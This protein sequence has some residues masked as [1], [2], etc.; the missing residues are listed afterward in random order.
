[1]IKKQLFQLLDVKSE[2]YPGPMPKG[3]MLAHLPQIKAGNYWVTPKIDGVRAILLVAADC[4]IMTRDMA[5]RKVDNSPK[6]LLGSIDAVT[7]LDGELVEGRVFVPCDACWVGGEKLIDKPFSVRLAHLARVAEAVINAPPKGLQIAFKP[8]VPVARIQ[9]LKDHPRCDGLILVDG[10]SAYVNDS[11]FK[12]K[13]QHTIDFLARS[14]ADKINLIMPAEDGSE[15]VVATVSTSMPIISGC[16][17]ECAIVGSG[18]SILKS[19][20]DKTRANA[21][22]VVAETI[23]IIKENLDFDTLVKTFS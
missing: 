9:E 7:V 22:M 11:L 5:V 15:K 17:V 6:D 12:W 10:D 2:R 8:I 3:L 1:M 20:P 14:E 19:R 21:P 16:I 4:H 23:K 18:W 13:K